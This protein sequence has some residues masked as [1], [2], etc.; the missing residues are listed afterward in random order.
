MQDIQA[1][2]FLRNM[3]NDLSVGERNQDRSGR[4]ADFCGR[5]RIDTER[6]ESVTSDDPSHITGGRIWWNSKALVSRDTLGGG[7]IRAFELLVEAAG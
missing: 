4:P 5:G 3:I 2:E 1:P 7:S 6:R